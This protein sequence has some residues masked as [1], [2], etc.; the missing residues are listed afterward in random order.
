MLCLSVLN[1]Y[2]VLR[3][4]PEVLEQT[5]GYGTSADIWSLGIMILELAL[6]G[7]PYAKL[8]PMKV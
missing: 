1:I 5:A 2:I 8:P 6:G 3:I 4:A 7:A